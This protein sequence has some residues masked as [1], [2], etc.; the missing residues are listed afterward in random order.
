MSNCGSREQKAC[1]LSFDSKISE[2][3]QI[4]YL[5]NANDELV[6]SI[7]HKQTDKV[8]RIQCTQPTKLHCIMYNQ[9]KQAR[10]IP[11]KP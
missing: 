4:Y 2:S 6:S 9:L 5:I 10:G 1:P 3:S 11:Q 8:P 7:V